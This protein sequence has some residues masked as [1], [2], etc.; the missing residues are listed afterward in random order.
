MNSEQTTVAVTNS[1][2]WNKNKEVKEVKEVKQQKSEGKKYVVAIIFSRWNLD[3]V[4]DF[5][6]DHASESEF[7]GPLRIDRNKGQ[8]TDRTICIMSAS[9]YDTLKES[10]PRRTYSC[11]FSITEYELRKYNHPKE[12]ET[13]KLFV[14]LPRQ[15]SA[16]KCALQLEDK[17]KAFT[18]AGLVK[19]DEYKV[20]VPCSSRE[21]NTHRGLAFVSFKRTVPQDVIC[22]IKLMLHDSWWTLNEEDT[23]LM[24]CNWARNR[25]NKRSVKEKKE[26]N[27]EGNEKEEKLE[28][29]S[30]KKS[31]LNGE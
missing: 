6:M 10:Y 22:V 24:K 21:V 25:T 20:D 16:S 17:M 19:Q 26:Q 18:Q 15:L 11:D 2:P 4:Y 30:L 31:E 9:L 13:Y 28:P 7:V 23:Q 27:G 14:H 5:I 29:L 8:E 3:T 12:D 1:N